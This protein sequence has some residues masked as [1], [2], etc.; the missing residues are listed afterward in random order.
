MNIHR[1]KG[2]ICPPKGGKKPQTRM[3]VVGF[4]KKIL[5]KNGYII[6]IFGATQM[7]I[8]W[9]CIKFYLAIK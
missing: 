1:K 3:F 7:P 6:A 9:E 4:F 8:I 2:K 5:F